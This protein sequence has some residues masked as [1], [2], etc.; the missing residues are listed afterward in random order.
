VVARIF[1]IPA[2][3]PGRRRYRADRGGVRMT[4]RSTV[5][6]CLSITLL[7]SWKTIFGTADAVQTSPG[8]S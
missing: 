6:R 8:R 3:G 7:R 5:R 2:R 1:P 4:S